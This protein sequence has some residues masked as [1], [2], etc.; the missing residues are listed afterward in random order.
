MRMVNEF[1]FGLV[2]AW[3]CSGGCRNSIGWNFLQHLLYIQYIE[4]FV[5]CFVANT[6]MNYRRISFLDIIALSV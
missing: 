3:R 4:P 5:P 2:L 6:L 1:I